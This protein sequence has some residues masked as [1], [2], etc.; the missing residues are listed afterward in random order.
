MRSA[1]VFGLLLI[2]FGISS[3]LRHAGPQGQEMTEAD[4]LFQQGLDLYNDEKRRESLFYFN[5]CLPM[6]EF[7]EDSVM[8]TVT[9]AALAYAYYELADEYT[10]KLYAYEIKWEYEVK[11]YEWNRAI[12][13]MYGFLGDELLQ[14]K[15][16]K[17]AK[18][19]ENDW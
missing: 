9:Q 12:S 4:K 13:D 19:Y 2:G 15:Y 10:A 17:R 18:K 1:S 14:V 11:G 5:K 7:A 16:L 8:I 3:F 6:F